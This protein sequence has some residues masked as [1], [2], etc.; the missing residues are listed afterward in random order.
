MLDFFYK[1]FHAIIIKCTNLGCEHL[2]KRTVRLILGFNKM[3][4]RRKPFEINDPE[5]EKE[6]VK[7]IHGVFFRERVDINFLKPIDW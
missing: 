7:G 3:F 6:L 5:R 2:V 1:E 4:V